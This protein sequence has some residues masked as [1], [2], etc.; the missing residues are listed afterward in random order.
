MLPGPW[1]PFWFTGENRPAALPGMDTGAGECQDFGA[2]GSQCFG[3]SAP[4][5]QQDPHSDLCWEQPRLWIKQDLLSWEQIFSLMALMNSEE[6][7]L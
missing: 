3:P 2:S 6:M 7:M 4:I 5:P 1:F